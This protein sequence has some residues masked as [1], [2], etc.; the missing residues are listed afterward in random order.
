MK[1]WGKREIPRE[2]PPANG[3]V[4]H[5]SHWQKSGGPARDRTRF[6]FIAGKQTN[7]SPTV[8]PLC[9]T[10]YKTRNLWLP[11]SA[12]VTWSTEVTKEQ[13]IQP[14]EETGS[15]RCEIPGKT[16]RPVAL[17]GTVSTCKNP[18]VTPLGIEPVC[19]ER[20]RSPNFHHSV[21]WAQESVELPRCVKALEQY[22]HYRPESLVGKTSRRCPA[23]FGGMLLSG[24][25]L[26]VFITTNRQISNIFAGVRLQESI[27]R[28]FSAGVIRKESVAG[29]SRQETVG[30]FQTAGASLQELACR[31]LSARV[32]L[33]STTGERRAGRFWLTLALIGIGIRNF[34]V[35]PFST[36]AAH[37]FNLGEGEDKEEVTDRKYSDPLRLS[38]HD[39]IGQEV[40][41]PRSKVKVADIQHG[42]QDGHQPTGM[43]E[44]EHLRC[45][46]SDGRSGILAAWLLTVIGVFAGKGLKKRGGGV[47]VRRIS[48]TFIAMW[49]GSCK[50]LQFT[51]WSSADLG[52]AISA[53][54]VAVKVFH[55]PRDYNDGPAS[56]ARKAVRGIVFN[57]LRRCGY[58]PASDPASRPGK[59]CC[60]QKEDG[61]PC[62]FHYGAYPDKWICQA[63]LIEW[64]VRSPDLTSTDYFLWGRVKRTV[65]HT[66]FTILEKLTGSIL[67]DKGEPFSEGGTSR[68]IALSPPSG[69]TV[70]ASVV[71]SGVD[72]RTVNEARMSEYLCR[73]GIAVDKEL[74]GEKSAS[75]TYQTTF[76]HQIR[77]C[78]SVEAIYR[79]FM[80]G[81]LQVNLLR[82]RCAHGLPSSFHPSSAV[83]EPGGED[84][85]ALSPPLKP[86][87]WN[88]SPTYTNAVQ[89]Y[90]DDIM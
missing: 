71:E 1:G 80:G 56:M 77:C 14:V 10:L 26:V 22:V 53:G 3:I 28:S 75:Y 78:S 45:S 16:C 6:A 69:N 68:G 15:G 48:A 4:R 42:R 39:V 79:L 70:T 82:H 29:V 57:I 63:G 87:S 51:A 46:T 41:G 58:R 8:A 21:M 5:D 88:V 62:Y 11:D 76:H 74:T 44:N 23:A 18:G 38:P 7:R 37:L 89:H 31:S 34:A 50:C 27:C 67:T 65:Y 52:Q 72:S 59:P 35:S 12:E 36:L 49:R 73:H 60:L 55:C 30:K 43:I 90:M 54:L 24:T 86:R 47:V 2:S 40:T 32:C 83:T 20:V 33:L 84:T 85:T 9:F 66:A 25:R 13:W 19:N 61:H 81:K 17:S 64:L